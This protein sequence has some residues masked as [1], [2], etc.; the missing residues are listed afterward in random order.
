MLKIKDR[1]AI[2]YSVI[3]ILLVILCAA[4]FLALFRYNV[5]S[6]SILDCVTQDV[7]SDPKHDNEEDV[8]V[9]NKSDANDNEQYVNVYEKT[10]GSD[11]EQDINVHEKTNGRDKEQ[12][13][14]VH[15]KTNGHDKETNRDAVKYDTKSDVIKQDVKITTK[16][17]NNKQTTVKY[18]A[19]KFEEKIV[20]NLYK[21]FF[22]ILAIAIAVIVILNFILSKKYALFALNP[23]NNFT[24]KVKQQQQSKSIDLIELPSAKDEIYDLTVAYN[25]AIGKIK[26]SYG[27]LQRLNSYASHELRN[28]LAV[29]RTKI[30]LKDDV[31]NIDNYI[32]KLNGTI[33]DIL[34]M[35]T[36]SLESYKED[37]D[38]ALVCAKVVDEYTIVF[39]N[40]EFNM[41]EDGV[42]LI[43]GREIWIERCI[44]NIIDNAIKFTDKDKEENKISINITED[45][46]E[47][48]IEIYDNGIG[49]PED[50]LEDIFIPYYGTKSRVSTGIGLAYVKH[51]MNLHKGKVLVESIKGEYTKFTLVFEDIS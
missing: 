20:A 26:E 35:S 6:K 23:L 31:S 21:R 27:N 37:V 32:K 39:E 2:I 42:D 49:I 5:N 8:D 50:K 33:T 46:K 29:L 43:K 14:N 13:V 3:S 30:E 34:A 1:I 11:E 45:T 22:I 41:P 44:V 24:D 16:S 18:S 4:I 28:S 36:N 38:L 47:I 25:E 9:K 51:I 40:I 48:K 7:V 10:N 17:A 19:D 12:D 15:K